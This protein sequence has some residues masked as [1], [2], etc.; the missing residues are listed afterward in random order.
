MLFTEVIYLSPDFIGN[1][2]KD[3]K[4]G[5]SIYICKQCGIKIDRDINAANNLEEYGK[6]N[7]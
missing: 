1:I 6:N 5:D 4:L 2:K 7:V 3:L